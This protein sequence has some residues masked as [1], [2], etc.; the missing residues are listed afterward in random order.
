VLRGGHEEERGRLR[1][2]GHERAGCRGSRGGR[3]RSRSRNSGARGGGIIVVVCE[4]EVALRQ[5][6]ER[7]SGRS[8]RFGW[9]GRRSTL[10]SGGDTGARGWSRCALLVAVAIVTIGGRR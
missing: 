5:A 9:R 7:G 1:G 4:A 10:R 6:S 3:S 2:H 8:S